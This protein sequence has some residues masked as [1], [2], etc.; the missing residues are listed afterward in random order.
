MKQPLR[1][2]KAM[3]L[4]V[5]CAPGENILSQVCRAGL[6]AAELYLSKA[7]LNDVP[8][9][10]QLCKDFPLRYAVHAPKDGT[11]IDK[12]AS[13]TKE[14][15]AEVV[16]F[17]NCYWEDEW[18]H[19]IRTFKN[20]KAKLCIE[21]TYSIHEPVK[22][23]RRYGLGRCVDLEHTQ[24]ECAGIYEEEFIALMKEASHIHL[25]GY[26]YGSQLWHTHIHHSPE[27]GLYLLGLLKKAG[28]SGFVVSEA[29]SSL[30]TYL[31]FKKL[32]KFYQEW[33]GHR[34]Q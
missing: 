10:I 9:T 1:K 7:L 29:K 21:N 17:H 18:E 22:F 16:V 24:L 23:I 20:I 34:C 11:V 19:T 13:L 2:D 28:Y 32:N 31:E 15:G 25:T 33:K 4:A 6:E 30:Q 8:R 14:I 26:I 12:V 5:K 3:M 27:H